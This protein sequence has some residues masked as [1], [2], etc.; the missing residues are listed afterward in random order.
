MSCSE[1][2][3][4]HVQPITFSHIK[5]S[6]SMWKQGPFP[7][8]HGYKIC[9]TNFHSLALVKQAIYLG[10]F[11]ITSLLPTWQRL[12]YLVKAQLGVFIFKPTS[13]F[14][15]LKSYAASLNSSV[16]S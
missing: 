1:I 3:H 6:R 7:P 10:I 15:A 5:I 11:L 13:E 9:E 8:Q 12:P 4:W 16:S 2:H 14:R